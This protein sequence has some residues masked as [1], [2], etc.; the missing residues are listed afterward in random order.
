MDKSVFLFEFEG[1][2]IVINLFVEIDKFKLFNIDKSLF[3]FG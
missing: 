1:F 2:S 3:L